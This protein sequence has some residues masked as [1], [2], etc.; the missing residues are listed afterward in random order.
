A[1]RRGGW[2]GDREWWGAIRGGVPTAPIHGGT[3]DGWPLLRASGSVRE[4][5]LPEFGSFYVSRKASRRDR[6]RRCPTA[7][8]SVAVSS[9]MFSCGSKAFVD[10]L[11][12]PR[13]EI[14]CFL[15]SD[16]HRVRVQ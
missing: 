2:S 13:C 15:Y 7:S 4:K 11:H 9:T 8:T 14:A 5:G 10:V 3:Q 16:S 1:V 6:S 12:V